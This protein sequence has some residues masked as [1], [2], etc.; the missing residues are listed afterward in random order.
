MHRNRKLSPN[1]KFISTVIKQSEY[2]DEEILEKVINKYY[3]PTKF[4]NAL[5]ELSTKKQ[6]LYMH[7]NISSLSY[8]HL[9]LYNLISD[10]KIKPKIIGISE[11]RLQK[12]K[13]HVTNISLPNYV[14]EYAPTESSK[15]G[16]LL[17]LDKNLKYNLWKDL[18]I[19]QKGM[20]EST[21]IEIINKNEKNMV[22]G[23]IYKHP[24]QTIPDFLDNHVL[25]LL[26]KLSNENK[27]ILIMGDFNIN[28]LNYDDK[29]TENFLDTM[30]S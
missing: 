15:G 22:A 14:Y 28:L 3:T 21:F 4:N 20:I 8:H 24:K 17:Y 29:N 12:S 1:P 2:F 9:E 30:F 7:L 13:Q 27:Q 25:P 6:N 18:N 23:C 26:E 11:S 19:Y 10:M 16:T 5:N